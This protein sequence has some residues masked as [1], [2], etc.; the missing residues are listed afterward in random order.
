MNKVFIISG[1]TC[2]GKTSLSVEV[3][4]QYSAEVV[5]FDS[6]LL[7]KELNIGT[8]KPTPSERGDVI[9]H[10]IDV[11]SISDPMNAADYRRLCAPLIQKLHEEKKSIIL[12]GG[13]GFYLQ[14]L[15]KGM[16][17]SATTPQDIQKKSDDLYSLEG[18]TPFLSILK[19]H[20]PLSF[21]KLHENDHYRLRRAVEHWWA[22]NEAFSLAQKKLKE[23]QSQLGLYRKDWDFFFSFLDIPK[24]EHWPLIQ[25]RTEKMLKNG[26]MN[27]VESLLSQGFTGNEKPLQSIGYKECVSHLRGELPLNALE[28]QISIATRQLAKSQRTWFKK[29]Q[30]TTFHPIKEKSQ[31][32]IKAQDFFSK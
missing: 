12:V 31:F 13:S 8:A 19:E 5:N 29:E 20:D 22:N 6:L 28:E 9:H 3:A 2:T 30:V 25:Q 16:F 23:Q 27:E 1:P 17:D 32:L 26:L 10:M 18:I 21:A 7:Y 14:A 11:R 24:E 4:R 15:M